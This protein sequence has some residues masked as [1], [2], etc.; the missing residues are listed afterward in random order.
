MGCKDEGERPRRRTGSLHV[1]GAGEP[2]D[3]L[4][5]IMLYK[6]RL[7]DVGVVCL[8]SHSL[9]ELDFGLQRACLE[10]QRRGRR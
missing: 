5:T 2:E 6:G 4:V 1:I 7:I 8:L 3:L 9:P 10:M